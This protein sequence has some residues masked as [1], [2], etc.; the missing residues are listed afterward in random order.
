MLPKTAGSAQAYKSMSFIWIVWSTLY[1]YLWL[2]A[3]LQTSLMQ[4][5][6]EVYLI[7]WRAPKENQFA[8]NGF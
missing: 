6:K 8:Q 2:T 3:Q 5:A 4:Q 1:V 7:E